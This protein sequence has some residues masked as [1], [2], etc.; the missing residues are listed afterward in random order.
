MAFGAGTYAVGF[1]AGIVSVLSPCVLPILPI[2]AMSA[3][4]RHRLGSVALASGLG[5]SFAAIGIFVAVIGV[6]IGLDAD[7]FRR[8]AAILMVLFGLMLLIPNRQ[9]VFVRLSSRIGSSSQR[10][11]DSISGDGLAGQFSIGLLLGVVWSPCVGPTLGA[12][13]TLAAQGKSIGSIALLLVL[14]GLGAGLPLIIFGALSRASMARIRG[15]LATTGRVAGWALGSLFAVLGTLI[16]TGADRVV[17][18]AILS[19]SP[20][21]LTA[22]T[23]SF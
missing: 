18:T 21:W 19:A 23:T 22:F 9:R 1:L 15:S 13:S 5:L 14:F 16:L 10:L 6:S 17:E 2:L 8:A 7:V 4:S 12:A 11:L 3:V 20:D